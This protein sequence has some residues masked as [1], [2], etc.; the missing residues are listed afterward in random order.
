MS[1]FMNLARKFNCFY[2]NGKYLILYLLL[3]HSKYFSFIFLPPGDL[4]HCRPF[5]V[6]GKQVGVMQARVVEAACRYPD[7]FQMDSS[8][9][10]SMEGGTS[11][12]YLKRLEKRG[13]CCIT[14]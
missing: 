6:C 2:F 10:I 8:G 1:K 3:N 7:V 4:Q 14:R 12:C 13:R 5:L 11:V 9:M